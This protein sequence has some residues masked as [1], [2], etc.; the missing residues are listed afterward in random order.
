MSVKWQRAKAWDDENLRGAWEPLRILLRVFSSVWTAVGLLVLAMLFFVVATTP[1]GLLAMLPTLAAYALSMVAAVGVVAVAPV[2][3]GAR[4]MRRVVPRRRALRTCVIILGSVALGAAAVAGWNRFVWPLMHYDPATGDGVRFFA[5]FVEKY[6]G[7][8]LRRLPGW[9]MSEI[10]FYSWWPLKLVLGLFVMNMMVATVRRIDF[11]FQKI[12]VLTVHTGIVLI[13]LGAIYYGKLKQEGDML[14]RAGLPGPDGIPGV[15]PPENVFYDHNSVALYVEQGGLR[16]QRLLR[17]VPRYNEYNLGALQAAGAPRSA[18]ETAGR[19]PAW[20]LEHEDPGATS[21]GLGAGT[22]DLPIESAA[23]RAGQPV[24]DNDID[25]RVVGYA[26]YA[27]PVEDWV[28]VDP[29]ARTVVRPGDSL[30]PVRFV[31]L[32]SQVPDETGKVPEGPA[33]S[34][35][36]A[37]TLA[38]ERIAENSAFGVEYTIGSDPARGG[39]SDQRF[40]DLGTQVP[41]GAT[42]A[43]LVEIPERGYRAVFAAEAGEKIAVGETGWTLEVKDLAAEP[44]FPIITRGYEDAHSSVAIVRVTPP[45]GE[46]S[47]E[48]GAAQGASGAF[49]RWVY[50]RFPEISQDMLDQV[51]AQGMPTRR[52]PDA[53][54]R[55]AYLDASKLQVFFNER[56][57]NGTP[58]LRGVVRLPGGQRTVYDNLESWEIPEV[59]AKIGLKVGERW[60]DA[61]RVERPRPEPDVSR[62]KQFV[63]TH[64]KAMLGVRVSVRGKAAGAAEWSRV[65]WLPFTKYLGVGLGTERTVTLPDGRR[66]VL[67]FG[68]AQHRLPEFDLEL[69]NFEMIAYEHRSVPRDYR[70]V[71]R[72]VPAR[73]GVGKFEGFVHVTQLN[74]P[75]RAP[76]MWSEDRGLPSN[77]AGRVLSGLSPRQYKFSQAGWDSEGWRRSQARADAGLIPRPFASFTILGVGNNPGIHIIA[78]GGVLMSVG[79]PWA[80][81]VKLWLN[82]RKRD[83]IKKQLAAGTYRK[84]ERAAAS[85]RAPVGEPEEVGSGR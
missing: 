53:R 46:A 66:F 9:E 72:V 78:L 10:E 37:P 27:E 13:A 22:L 32:M 63:G 68:R 26:A 49:E 41:S 61:Q 54:I 44:P 57:E 45:A 74:A 79:I 15:G 5:G 40:E 69:V 51:N 12:G 23:A 59:V 85:V 43:L 3:F 34:F 62:D 31:Y 80:F 75:L 2:W 18:L 81:Y 42:H 52:A 77:V 6:K 48:A 58:K 25:L 84:P 76:F 4:V 65:V 55:I 20:A 39:M 56:V 64:D 14:L 17:R 21:P 7:T 47:G 73:G 33:Y 24:L 36:L 19:R 35:I 11:T 83:K 67:A 29:A 70:S 50:H 38:S 82:T 28:R 60:D 16:E 71:V 1:I 30:T 8:V